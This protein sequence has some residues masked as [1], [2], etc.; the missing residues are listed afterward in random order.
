MPLKPASAPHP[1]FDSACP[2]CGEPFK[3]ARVMGVRCGQYDCA[4]CQGSFILWKNSFASVRGEPLG[5][6][7]GDPL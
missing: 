3:A 1:S 4:R 6:W 2:H 7:L 5:E